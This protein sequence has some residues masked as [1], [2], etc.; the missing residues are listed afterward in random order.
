MVTEQ[1]KD[2]LLEVIYRICGGQKSLLLQQARIRLKHWDDDTF[3][4]TAKALIDDKLIAMRF[5]GY[6]AFTLAGRRRTEKNLYPYPKFTQN[7]VTADT[8]SNSPIQQGGTND[9]M[10]QTVSYNRNNLD[11]LRH[12]V[13]VFNKH[14][15]DLTLD[16]AA[17]RKVM[18]Q[19]ATIK[20]QLENDPDP[21]IMKQAGWML[22]NITEGAIGRLIATTVQPVVWAWA[23]SVIKKLFGGP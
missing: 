3:W 12:L 16:V 14:L 11:E 5:W 4:D 17:K 1:N 22:W 9:K 10:T 19:V 6:A 7:T 20:A 21:V 23:A 2:D 15:D 18:V 8:I 13:D